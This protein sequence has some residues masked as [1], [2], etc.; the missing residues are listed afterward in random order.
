MGLNLLLISLYIHQINLT[1]SIKMNQKQITKLLLFLIFIISN[2]SVQAQNEE[3]EISTKIEQVTIHLKGAEII[4]EKTLPI[5]QGRSTLIFNNLSPKLNPKSILITASNG[6]QIL[7][8][9]SKINFLKEGISSS[10]IDNLKDSL[11]LSQFENS[12]LED[13]K[14][15]YLIEKETILENQKIGGSQQGLAV[16]ELKKM[17]DFIRI[18]IKEINNATTKIIAEQKI[19][20]RNIS[21][22][23]NQ[24]KELNASQKPTSEVF[25][26]ITCSEPKES[27][28]KLRYVVDNAGWSPIYDLTA[29][30]IEEPVSL[31]YR[32]LAFNDTENDWNEVKI[33]L[34]TADPYQSAGQPEL[35]PWVLNNEVK[36]SLQDNRG[37]ANYL[38]SRQRSQ[39]MELANIGDSNAKIVFEKIE[40]GELSTIYN[41]DNLYTIPSDKK[42][43]SIEIEEFSLEANY[44]HY[45]VPKMEKDAFLLAQ[46]LGWED[47]DLISGPMNV[48]HG[49]EF[50][51]LA[52][53]DTRTLS[54][55]LELSLGRDK[56]VIITR[57]KLKEF[58]KKRLLGSNEISN[59]TFQ[60]QVKN[61][62]KI[63]INLEVLDQ[64]PVSRRK[65]ISIDVKETSN[66]LHFEES[67]TLKWQFSLTPTEKRIMKFSYS[68][69]HPKDFEV[70]KIKMREV[71]SPRYF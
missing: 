37:R 46:I 67:G 59:F 32:A 52:D 20:K 50:I 45:A 26:S 47:L 34:S 39:N 61:N 69:K 36:K 41:I 15:A 49:A 17:A 70:R 56:K 66:A 62:H 6:V 31:N 58:S 54:D 12:L 5:P 14:A 13:E 64:V 51:G 8:V 60:I 22:L 29:T 7:S 40:I 1:I 25:V 42:P 4:R 2:L 55:T 28:L 48:Y 11:E 65:E 19:I 57:E 35:K 18:R 23:N 43:Y 3:I 53:L 10:K 21:R 71:I 24:L 63:P 27:L 9:T 33:T 68:V 44:K 30:S 16:E 38:P